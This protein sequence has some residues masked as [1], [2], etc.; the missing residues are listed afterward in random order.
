VADKK[1]GKVIGGVC[2][3]HGEVGKDPGCD[4]NKRSLAA[5]KKAPPQ[6]GSSP[7]KGGGAMISA[8]KKY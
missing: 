6:G 5:M 1:T 7:S 4:F 3:P 2:Y 8:G